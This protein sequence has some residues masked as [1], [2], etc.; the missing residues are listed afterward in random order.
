MKDKKIS[1]LSVITA[2]LIIGLVILGNA[3]KA[4]AEAETDS[5]NNVL[6]IHVGSCIPKGFES[7]GCHSYSFREGYWYN[8]GKLDSTYLGTNAYI[9]V[10]E[11]YMIIN[12]KS[13]DV[14]KKYTKQVIRDVGSERHY[15]GTRLSDERIKKDLDALI[16]RC[17][18]KNKITLNE[19]PR[20]D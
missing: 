17:K 18:I 12:M 16:T 7:K 4:T 1:K 2:Y 11:N 9:P 13:G 6:T 15:F 14:I 5:C 19:M 8:R 3:S 10:I 20:C